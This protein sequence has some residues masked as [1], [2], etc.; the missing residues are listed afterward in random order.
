MAAN[1]SGVWIS[2]VATLLISIAPA[3]YQTRQFQA[4]VVASVLGLMWAGYVVR[5][6]Q[7]A[8]QYQRRLDERVNERTRIARELHDGLLQSFHAL[9]LKFQ[10]V[11]NLLPDRPRT[12]SGVS[13]QRSRRRTKRSPKAAT[14][15][16][17]ADFHP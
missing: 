14:R 15:C 13:K 8:R 16:R 10:T 6:R 9:V 2:V 3:F 5:V 12:R 4:L 11:L 17:A 1:N 7:V